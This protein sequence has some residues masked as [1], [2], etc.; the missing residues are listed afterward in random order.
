MNRFIVASHGWSASNYVAHVLNL[1]PQIACAHSS[2]A[3]LAEDKAMFDG[4]NLR[5]LIP[6]LRKGYL[7]R[8]QLG[9]EDRYSTLETQVAELGSHLSNNAQTKWLGTVH[10]YRMRDLPVQL[11]KFEFS[12]GRKYQLVNLVRHPLDLVVSGF[13]QFLD[14]FK[15]DINEYAWSLNK[16][17]AVRNGID[18]VEKAVEDTEYKPGDYEVICFASACAVLGSLRLDVDATEKLTV[19]EG[20]PFDYLG[21]V[22]MEDII[23]SPEAVARLAYLLTSGQAEISDSYLEDVAGVKKV[24]RHNHASPDGTLARWG[25]LPPWQKKLFA[26]FFSH[27]ELRTPYENMGYNFDFLAEIE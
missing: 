13:G 14:L 6:E 15:V 25:M 27:F 22:L 7:A 24:N 18:F 2:A 12:C 23:S 9:L 5:Q 26:N 4:D 1:H 16:I 10:T 17:I 11:E 3:I 8:Q 19:Y 20:A 21:P